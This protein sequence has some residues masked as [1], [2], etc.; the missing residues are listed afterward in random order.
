MDEQFEQLEDI[1]IVEPEH[2]EQMVDA[3]ADT[4]VG[5][6]SYSLTGA[7]T[8]AIAVLQSAGMITRQEAVAGNE[9]F[10]DSIADG[11]KKVWEYIQKIFKGIWNWFF[12]PKA[13]GK[14]APAEAAKTVKDNT[15]QLKNAASGSG[16]EELPKKVIETVE[17]LDRYMGDDASPAD[18]K[19][20][21]DLKEKVAEIKK[22]APAQQYRELKPM[23]TKIAKLNRRTQRA[24]EEACNH[25]VDQWKKY[26]EIFEKA[27]GT[28]FEGTIYEENWKQL[29][30]Y[31]ADQKSDPHEAY[32]RIPKNMD[33]LEHA[34]QAQAD[35][36][37]VVKGIEYECRGVSSIYKSDVIRQ[38]K[39]LQE[40]L[41]KNLK[42]D[43]RAK[44]NKDLAACKVFLG[45]TTRMIKQME[46]TCEAIK[47]ISNMIV[48]LFGLK[49]A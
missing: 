46:A 12:G 39:H 29:L 18:K 47:R 2:I 26:H 43:N 32:I 1:G 28:V 48:R 4:V 33:S 24:I 10:M 14:E 23:F 42:D 38:I 9:G 20:A 6:E 40:V 45:I 41:E 49:P 5:T 8:Y 7:Q 37:K 17:D 36:D 27:D 19:E 15:T 44:F 21:A 25:A 11:A 3:L 34:M 22:L 30:Q 31:G 13:K 16:G 35:L